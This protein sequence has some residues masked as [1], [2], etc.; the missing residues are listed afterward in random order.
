MST[1]TGPLRGWLA[2]YREPLPEADARLLMEEPGA[3]LRFI[4]RRAVHDN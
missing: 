1:L 2:A 3:A 4:R